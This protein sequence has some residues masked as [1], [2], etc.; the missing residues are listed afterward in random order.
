M[1]GLILGLLALVLTAC[2]PTPTDRP[3]DAPTLGLTSTDGVYY[4]AGGFTAPGDS[5]RLTITAN[6]ARAMGYI[7]TVTTIDPGWSGLP[8][9][10]A[11]TTGSLVFTAIHLTAWDSVRFTGC[12]IG[13]QG[14]KQSAQT[15]STVTFKRGPGAPTVGWDSSLTVTQNILKPDAINALTATST[16]TCSY[17]KALDGYVRMQSGQE[18][19]LPCQEYYDTMANTLPGYPVAMAH[20][21][22]WY[23]VAPGWRVAVRTPRDELAHVLFAGP[24]KEAV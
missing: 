21:T 13:T 7:F 19:L 11:T 22:K 1:R 20:T 16:Q 14:A 15:C 12:A 18:N 24:F 4:P 9:G 2:T 5:L 17:W 8:T 6:S 23:D 3:L 10:V